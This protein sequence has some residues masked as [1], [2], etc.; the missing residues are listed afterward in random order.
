MPQASVATSTSSTIFTSSFRT[1]THN[2]IS[3][4]VQQR[5]EIYCDV[6]G[7]QNKE[8]GGEQIQKQKIQ[9]TK[10]ER[11]NTN[12]HVCRIQQ[13]C[14]HRQKDLQCTTSTALSRFP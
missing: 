13:A 8:I 9:N 7:E 4:T 2:D 11:K 14:I 12:T 6:S 5:R 1:I 10:K 3:S